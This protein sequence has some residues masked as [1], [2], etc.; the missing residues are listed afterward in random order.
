MNNKRHSHTTVYTGG[1]IFDG[2]QLLEHH[3]AVITNGT[4]TSVVKDWEQ[5]HSTKVVELNGDVLSIGYADLQVNGGGGVLLNDG[6]SVNTL[7]T[8]AAA[9]RRLGTTCLLPTLITDTPELTEAAIDAVKEAIDAQSDGIAGLHLEGPHLSVAKKGAHQASL[10]RPMQSNDL[11]LLLQAAQDLPVLKVTI[12]PENVTN[13]QVHTL[14]EAGVIIALGHT[15]ANYKTCMEYQK[16]GAR[17]VTHLFNAMSQLGSREPGLV[18][19]A[20][21]APDLSV[22]LIADGVHVHP[23]SIRAAWARKALRQHLY[24]VTDA[25]TPAGTAVDSFQLNGRTIHRSDGRL[26]LEDGTLAGADIDMTSAIRFLR[27]EVGVELVDALRAAVEVPRLLLGMDKAETN[28]VGKTTK[29]IIRISAN[30]DAVCS[31]HSIL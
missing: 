3:S 19:A 1:F 31:I 11:N 21:D 26:T 2:Q 15:N 18:G 5:K 17:C 16:A 28:I 22:G 23:A 27:N 12:A 29:D 4:C 10:I 6:P 13:R 9:H 20:F 7:N 8:I 24:L 25:M 30:L 14:A